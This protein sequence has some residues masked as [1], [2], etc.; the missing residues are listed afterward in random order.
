MPNIESG[1]DAILRASFE[2]ELI[3]LSLDA[4]IKAGPPEKQSRPNYIPVL[5]HDGEIRPS[6]KALIELFAVLLSELQHDEPTVGVVFRSDGK[7]STIHLPPGLKTARTTLREM[8]ELHQGISSPTLVLNSHC[9]VC[10]FHDRCLAQALKDDNIS[11]LTGI[12]EPEIIR[13]NKK[14]I[15]TV[16]QLS[17]TFKTRRRPKRAKKSSYTH[18]FPLRA[19][20]LREK[21][22]FVHGNPVVS[23]NGTRIYLDI[24]GTP[25]RRTYYLIGIIAIAGEHQSHET[26]WADSDSETDQTR[27][28]IE[29]LDH[30]SRYSEY[31]ILHFGSYETVAFRR[32]QKRMTAPYQRQMQNALKR[33]INILSVIS[34]HIYFPT[35]SNSLKEIGGFLG[36][37]WSDPSSSGV[38][39]LVWRSRWLS[40]H[41][42]SVKATLIQYNDED[43][44]ALK[45]VV[46]FVEQVLT[47]GETETLR[48]RQGAEIVPTGLL[49]ARKD[50]QSLFGATDFVLDEFREINKLSYFDYQRD[51]VY[52]RQRRRPK[53]AIPKGKH[54]TPRPNKIIRYRAAKCPSCHSRELRALSQTEYKVFD[55]KF[56][57]GGVKRWNVHHAA[58]RYCCSTCGS[59][60]IPAAYRAQ[61][62]LPKYG[63]GLISWCMYQLL[64]GGQ[65]INRI[66]RSL[67]ELFCLPI[68]NASVYKFKKA[69]AAYFQRGYDDILTDL[70]SGDLI[71]VDETTINLQ[72]DKGYVWVFASSR[73]VYFFYRNSREGSFLADLLKSFK[74]VLVSD[75]YTAYDSLDMPQQR[76][77]IHLIR[78]M[79]EDLLKNSFDNELKSI[80]TRFSSLL[81]TIVGT[82]DKY[83]LKA[84]HLNKHR[85]Q[86]ERF[87]DQIIAEEFSSDAAKNYAR[88]IAKYRGYLFAFLAYDGIPWNN[89]NAEH[90]IKG[91]A[92]FRRFSNGVVTEDSV[93][94]Y[95]VILSIC[96]TCE[97]RGIEF[98][99]VLL[100]GTKGDFGFGPKRFTPLRLPASRSKH[101]SLQGKE[102]AD[103]PR[104]VNLNKLLPQMFD[105]LG[106]VF[107]HFRYQA[108]LAPDLWPVQLHP[109]ALESIINAIVYI[110]R[111]RDR[112]RMVILRAKNVRFEGPHPATG[113][114]GR[115]VAVSLSEGGRIEQARRPTHEDEIP[116]GF[117]T[118]LSFGQVF[119]RAKQLGGRA[120]VES[121]RTPRRSAV[122]IV[123]TYIPQD[124]SLYSRVRPAP[125]SYVDSDPVATV[126]VFDHISD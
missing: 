11:L 83:G 116:E 30:L 115:Y 24:E 53:K 67:L 113:L 77:L 39:T 68:P 8:R 40:D 12:T 15:F 18:H 87:C 32:M 125:S 75:F 73:S 31:S 122:T 58:W 70:L 100:G 59:R 123:T 7:L 106:N 42:A 43:C 103:K 23:P 120:T 104:L 62:N 96:L 114:I 108:E 126:T 46:E 5:F 97:Y 47:V 88:R 63:R 34:P 60:F 93:S 81:K 61:T 118:D 57:H 36:Y 27:I 16:N 29:L 55:L 117:P 49:A 37:R 98:L 124:D 92:K 94:D 38:Q 44:V 41:D 79:N 82:I 10:E 95:L 25:E 105:A 50:E 14:G 78:D 69:V 54:K 13:L 51:K 66:H 20:A 99:K 65:N 48:F 22:V 3:S 45:G 111:K 71:N 4:L 110:F 80:A 107:Q 72:K 76:C 1:P 86:A 26:Y 9:Q 109:G 56:T 2:N 102:A 19:L 33:S 101:T 90:A 84:R 52:A 119:F 17:Y 112:C 6:Q 89:N 121:V 64:I 85:L 91:F 35:Y 21:K 28:F 74:G